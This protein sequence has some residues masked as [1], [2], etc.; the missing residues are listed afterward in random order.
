MREKAAEQS[1]SSV[2]LAMQFRRSVIIFRLPTTRQTQRLQKVAFQ[3]FA[4]TAS[5]AYGNTFRDF[6]RA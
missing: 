1:L 5:V 3:P 6:T 2:N 4:L